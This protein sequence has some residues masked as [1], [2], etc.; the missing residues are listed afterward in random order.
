MP[1]STTPATVSLDP[2]AAYQGHCG[3]PA[4]PFD[5]AMAPRTTYPAPAHSDGQ[6]CPYCGSEEVDY[7]TTD[8][9]QDDR[10]WQDG[11]CFD[12]QALWREIYL[13]DR[14]VGLDKNG[15]ETGPDWPHTVE[16]QRERAY[17]ELVAAAEEARD[18]LALI[19]TD[20]P[21]ALTLADL[22]E[23]RM[24]LLQAL[25]YADNHGLDLPL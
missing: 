3:S 5:F 21:Q 17:Q 8:G 1:Q 15:N 4:D 6:G 12:C 2:Q 11:S 23:V 9:P 10:V 7:R 24:S 18:A 19:L 22:D 25:G 14:F 16:Y 20:G 13:L